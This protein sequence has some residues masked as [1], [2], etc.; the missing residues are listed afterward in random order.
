[1]TEVYKK[2]LVKLSLYYEKFCDVIP[3]IGGRV[4]GH[5][6]HRAEREDGD[7]DGGKVPHGPAEHL[8]RIPAPSP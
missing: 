6:L 8:E 3:E 2:N 7:A 1:M 4:H 5:H